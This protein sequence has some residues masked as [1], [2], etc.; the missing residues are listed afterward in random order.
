M[1][2]ALIAVS[3][4]LPLGIFIII[5]IFISEL[6]NGL[7][8]TGSLKDL[9]I[10]GLLSGKAN[11]IINLLFENKT[12]FSL[13]GKKVFVTVFYKGS[14]IA[15]S[16]EEVVINLDKN[17]TKSVDIPAV[18]VLDSNSGDLVKSLMAKKS[19]DLEINIKGRVFLIPVSTIINY[20]YKP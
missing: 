5:A 4:F 2:K 18:I 6:K 8:V 15:T 11:I 17:S 14:L 3:I 16:S 7:K 20:T 1:K 9:K 12:S 10:S 13:I 19:V